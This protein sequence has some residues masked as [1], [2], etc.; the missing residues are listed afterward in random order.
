MVRE[1]SDK[2]EKE[3]GARLGG[4]KTLDGRERR[5]GTG[6][7]WLGLTAIARKGDRRE[8][9]VSQGWSGKGGG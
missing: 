1:K 4:A 7:G 2:T 3:L 6:A 5:R 8:R 9:R